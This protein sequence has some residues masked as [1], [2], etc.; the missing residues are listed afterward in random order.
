VGTSLSDSFCLKCYRAHLLVS[1]IST[2]LIVVDFDVFE[3]N[4]SHF[5]FRFKFLTMGCLDLQKV[6]KAPWTSI[7]VT[8]TFTAHAVNKAILHQQALVECGTILASAIWVNYHP[9]GMP[10]FRSAIIRALPTRS[11]VI[12]SDIAQPTTFLEYKTITVARYS[13]PSCVYK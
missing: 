1:T 2:H 12:H 4:T 6:E 3:F 9:L 10:R 5:L 7:M 13:H 11:A 8:V